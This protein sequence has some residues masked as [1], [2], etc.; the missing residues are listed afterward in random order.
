MADSRDRAISAVGKALGS[1]G[2]ELNNVVGVLHSYTAFIREASQDPALLADVQVIRSASD[3]AAGIARQ[4]LAF[5]HPNE[6]EP[7]ALDL[8]AF[9]ADVHG[10]SRRLLTERQL[11]LQLG[12]EPAVVLVRR[13]ELGRWLLELVLAVSRL[14]AH[15]SSV[16]LGVSLTERGQR[17][18]LGEVWLREQRP[19]TAVAT[20]AL[21]PSDLALDELRAF[22]AGQGG[23]LDATFTSSSGIS[24]SLCF[25]V[26]DALE[27]QP[28]SE[29]A[30]AA[31]DIRGSETV[32]V[33]ED[34]DELRLAICR[35]LESAGY[36]ALEAENAEVARSL[37]LEGG[38][39]VD[40]LL[41]SGREVSAVADTLAEDLRSKHPHLSVLRQMKPFSSDELHAAVRF[42]LDDRARLSHTVPADGERV[43]ALVVDDDQ[44]VRLALSRLLIDAGADVVTAPTGLHALQK[45]Q[46]LPI[47]LLIA[48]QLMPGMDGTRLLETAY[49]TWPRV[50]RVVYT[51]YLSSGLVVDAVNRANV[52]KVLAKDMTP[53]SLRD[54]LAEVVAEIRRSR[55]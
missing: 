53:D 52:H 18:P 46:A 30:V 2:H 27:G 4:L 39:S 29:P 16:V 26:L 42:S 12:A 14:A 55:P 35:M 9:V 15:E 22:A 3:K 5:G 23:A 1:I 45:L 17:E 20:C 54:E 49:R 33:V 41:A 47:D 31:T 8:R 32:L 10:F 37:G 43:L 13:A 50:V 44:H 11:G 51:G 25:P 28:P 48:D 21:E 36:R 7:E 19:S 40:L 6:H 38:M 34:D 24:V